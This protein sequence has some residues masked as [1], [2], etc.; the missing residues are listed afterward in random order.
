MTHIL[1]SLLGTACLTVAT[2]YSMLALIAV[3]VWRIRSSR[4][5]PEKG[6]QPPVTILKPLCGMEPGLRAHLRT[7]CLQDY[8]EYQLVFGVRDPTDPA[9][10]IVEDLIAEFPALPICMVVDPRLW[11]DNFKSSNL[12][13]MLDA[14]RHDYLVIADSDAIVGPHY[15]GIVTAPLQ[16]SQVGLVTCIYRGVPTPI[17]WSRLGAMY[18][19]EWFIPSVLVAWLFGHQ[20]FASGQTMCLRR[21]TLEAMGGLHP[22]ANHL[23]DDYRLG[24]LV[25][26]LGLRIV[27][28][29][30]EIDAEHHERSLHSLASHQLRWMRTLQVLRPGSFRFIFLTFSL[31]LAVLG[32]TLTRQAP[33]MAWSGATWVMFML[34]VSSQLA[35]HLVH[36]MK[37]RSGSFLRDLTLLPARDALL[38]WTWMRTFF[39]SRVK[40]RGA[41]FIVDAQGVMHRST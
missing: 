37:R 5:R 27:V 3:L 41:E 4:T 39:V 23:A 31:P 25:R 36:R 8:P 12:M 35:L 14:A 11:G 38:C 6:L 32:F 18:I 33:I 15:L 7:F 16:S 9:I 13:N 17:I 26:Q 34:T 2:L 20:S 30:Y 10:A 29:S 40:W 24:E 21:T 19:N 1:M 28:S 22:I